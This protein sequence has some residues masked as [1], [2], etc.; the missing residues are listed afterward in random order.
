[1]IVGIEADVGERDDWNE[2][3]P[4][5]VSP[6]LIELGGILISDPNSSMDDRISPI[7]SHPSLDNIEDPTFNSQSNRLDS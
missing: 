1:V 5:P 4:R 7:P 2:W 3:W 6:L